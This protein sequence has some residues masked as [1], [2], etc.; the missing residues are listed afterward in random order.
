MVSRKIIGIIFIGAVFLS[1]IGAFFYYN[2]FYYNRIKDMLPIGEDPILMLPLTNFTHND[3]IGG[4]GQITPEF[5]HNGIDFGINDTTIVVAAY[6]AYVSHVQ[7]NWFNDKGGHWQSN[8]NLRL[9][10]YWTI[11]IPFESWTIDE[12]QGQLQANEIY[13][14]EGQY[15]KK[16]EIIGT[17]LCHG[18][19][20]HIHFGLLYNNEAVCPYNYFNSSAKIIF[21]YQYSLVGYPNEWCN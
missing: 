19:A 4:F 1:I 2:R 16:G 9:N 15:V 14:K 20:A 5:F 21:E 18:D 17:L 7:L 10:K 8:V 6:D 3:M 12:N 11:T 13:V